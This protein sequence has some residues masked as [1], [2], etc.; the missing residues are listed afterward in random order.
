MAAPNEI[1]ITRIYDAPP[2]KVWDAWNIPEQVAAWWGPRGF[3]IT[4]IQKDVRPGGTWTFTMHGPD[5]VDFPNE[6]AFLEVEEGARLIYDHGAGGGQPPMF[7]VH[8]AFTAVGNK[9]QL[10]MRMI[11]AT[12]EAA[13]ETRKRVKKFGGNSTWDRLA[14]YLNETLH[15]KSSFVLNRTFPC[16]VERMYALWTDPTHIA[17][18]LAP[19]G[20]TMTFLRADIRVGGETF[21]KMVTETG[22]VMFGSTHYSEM[23]KPNRLSYT[24]LFRTETGEISRHPMAPLWPESMRTVVEFIEEGPNATRVTITWEPSEKSTAEEIAMF[25]G[26]RA[27]MTQGWTGSLDKLDE[28]LIAS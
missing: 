1:A 11:L 25:C 28:H 10:D 27:G 16:S 15:K 6:I 26:A 18:W 22:M 21:Y 14:E 9:T 4:T 23:S 12:A 24:Q 20:S 5:G 13:E 19:T 3:T 8:V 2:Q 17:N 7:Q